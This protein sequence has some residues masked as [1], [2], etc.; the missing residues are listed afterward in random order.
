MDA[1][2]NYKAKDTSDVV[3]KLFLNSYCQLIV[4]LMDPALYGNISLCII[5]LVI[6]FPSILKLIYFL[7]TLKTS[8]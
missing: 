6:S 5:F 1:W 4:L 3:K 2:F 7:M 8:Y